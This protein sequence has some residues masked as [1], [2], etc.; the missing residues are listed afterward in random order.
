[1]KYAFRFRE[2]ELVSCVQSRPW[3]AEGRSYLVRLQKRLL[4]LFELN[5]SAS[6]HRNAVADATYR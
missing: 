1:M 5:R 4:G 3:K 2:K 6:G